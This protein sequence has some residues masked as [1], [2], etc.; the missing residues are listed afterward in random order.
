MATS[1][2]RITIENGRVQLTVGD[3]PDPDEATTWV[4]TQTSVPVDERRPLAEALLAALQHARSALDDEI[5]RLRS[6]AGRA[7]GQSP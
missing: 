1:I 6:L 4:Y 5:A 2:Q 7:S 3:T